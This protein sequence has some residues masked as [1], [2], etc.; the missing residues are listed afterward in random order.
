[1]SEK[2]FSIQLYPAAKCK[3]NSKEVLPEE[4]LR[5]VSC[6][7]KRRKLQSFLYKQKLR[8]RP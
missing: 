2:I 1:M 3:A 7:V 4:T 6:V 5:F 8:G